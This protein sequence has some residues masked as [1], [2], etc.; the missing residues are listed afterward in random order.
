VLGSP[1]VDGHDFFLMEVV[2]LFSTVIYFNDRVHDGGYLLPHA[3]CRF[4]PFMVL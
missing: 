4:D 2:I 3:T 1:L